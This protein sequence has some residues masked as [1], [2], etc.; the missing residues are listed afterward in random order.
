MS[1]LYV[2]LPYLPFLLSIISFLT[3]QS[4]T[5]I[6]RTTEFID[7]VFFQNE[8]LFENTCVKL[9]EWMVGYMAILL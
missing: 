9:K 2:S 4:G 1:E 7:C 8:E 5:W 3:W 6:S